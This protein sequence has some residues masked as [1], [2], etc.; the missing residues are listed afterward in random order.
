MSPTEL[1]TIKLNDL[2]AQYLELRQEI[3]SA[4]SEVIRTSAFIRG[5]YVEEFE[6]QWAAASGATHC[7]SCANG[8]DALFIAMKALGLG[9]GDEVITTAMSWI[10]TS[11]SVTLTGAQVVFCDIE[12]GSFA[13]DTSK[14]EA[15]VTSRT[16]GIIPVHLYGQP[17]DMDPLL[18]IARRHG[19]WVLEDCAQAHLARYKGRQVGTLGIAGT[20][21]FYPGKNLGAMGAA[22]CIVT[23]DAALAERM[24]MFARHRGL[25]KGDHAI[26]GMNSR[27]DQGVALCVT[28][29][30][31]PERLT[32]QTEP[33][34]GTNAWTEIQTDFSVPLQ[35]HLIG[36]SVCR[37]PSKYY[38]RIAGAAWV[39]AVTLKP[40]A[41]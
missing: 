8:T 12:P 35:T 34:L 37:Q 40:V 17:V 22:G 36:V 15:L 23:S 18:D 32:K 25:K 2:H 1:K 31:S 24:A 27:S 11:E 41:K 4:I 20:F 7:V 19:L 28:D 10:A 6:R 29:A 13:L 9:P 5:P 26:E 21:S 33:L 30:E 16:K 14:L 39:D 38:S 3:D